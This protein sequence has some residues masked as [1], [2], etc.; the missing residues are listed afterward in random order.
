MFYIPEKVRKLIGNE[1]YKI[2]TI[3]M[4]GNNVLVFSDKVLKIRSIS[5]ESRN[6]VKA[7]KWLF[8]KV[9]VPKVI[10]EEIEDNKSYLL[11]TKVKGQMA[12]EEI[13]MNGPQEL[14]E[15][16]ADA[17]QKLWRIDI[18]DCPID[19]TL[20]KKLEIAEFYVE[21]GLVDIENTEPDTFGK[22]GFKNPKALLKWLKDNRPKEEPVLSHGDF[23]LPNIF[24]SDDR[25]VSFIDLGRCSVTDRWCDIAIC[26]RSL[27]DNYN[28]KYTDKTYPKYN[29]NLL[30][31]KLRIEPNWDKLRY[32]LLLDELF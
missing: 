24:I 6:E 7:L 28:G 19:W 25:T 9:P 23:S 10:Y 21:N 26:Y 15:I 17:L 20:D 14:T 8:D 12:C 31:K 29:P 4:S 30:F 32:Y 11:M 27:R 2:D 18:S 3:G 22:N 13:F 1:P 16:L 5:D